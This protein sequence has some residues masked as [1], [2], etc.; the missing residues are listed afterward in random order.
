MFL[1]TG[2]SLSFMIEYR[3]K[4]PFEN[5]WAAFV[6]TM[7]MMTSEF[8]YD[9]LVDKKDS[10]N[11]H[12]SLIII[13]LLFLIFLILA[14]I[15]LMNLMVAVAVNDL[16]DLE[17]LG[18]ILRLEKQVEFLASLETLVND[19]WFMK[20]LPKRLKYKLKFA[21][22]LLKISLK[23]CEPSWSC[24]K[25]LPSYV[26]D[27]IIDIAQTQKEKIDDKVD[28]DNL[29][30]KIDHI[31]DAVIN[32]DSQDEVEKLEVVK[33]RN[34]YDFASKHDLDAIKKQIDS[35]DTKLETIFHYIIR[36]KRNEF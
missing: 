1:V 4:I 33:Q 3:S 8:D 12:T 25:A 35:I 17:V 16:N 19:K 31:L 2:F 6:K 29:Q 22:S 14:A 7:V 11:L 26:R 10:T 34:G 20:I 28:C 21:R 13:R 9:D 32:A 18:N 23:P 36:M 15:V 24:S 27:A 5:P 30:K